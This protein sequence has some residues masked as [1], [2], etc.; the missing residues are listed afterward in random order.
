MEHLN[1]TVNG[2][3]LND[4]LNLMFGPDVTG[5]IGKLYVALDS[6]MQQGY[7]LG[8][9]DGQQK[10]DKAIDAAFDHGW[11]LGYD[12]GEADGLAEAEKAD[13][14]GYIRGVAD[15]RARPTVADENVVEIISDMARN[16]INGEFD[17]ELVRDSGDEDGY[18]IGG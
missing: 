7:E 3:A 12:E 1:Q 11:D 10:A 18:T 5:I 17:I 6:A 13:D 15:A 8:N 9:I 16:A 2:K 4:A 14:A